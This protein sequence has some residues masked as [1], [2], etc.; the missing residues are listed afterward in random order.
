MPEVCRQQT[1]KVSACLG[2]FSGEIGKFEVFNVRYLSSLKSK[3]PSSKSQKQIAVGF[4]FIFYRF[5]AALKNLADRGR[6]FLDEGHNPY[7]DLASR[8]TVPTTISLPEVPWSPWSQERKI[9]SSLLTCDF[10]FNH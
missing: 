9:S 7:P 2:D 5:P 3:Y 4:F 10:N 8:T 6:T 1:S